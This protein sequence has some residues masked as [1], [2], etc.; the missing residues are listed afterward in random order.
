MLPGGRPAQVSTENGS[1]PTGECDVQVNEGGQGVPF[2][3][4]DIPPR[5]MLVAPMTVA[6][7]D[8]LSA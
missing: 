1:W 3:I 4:I 5:M 8:T 7:R 6:L 2:W